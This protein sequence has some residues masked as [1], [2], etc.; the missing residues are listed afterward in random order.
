M[1]S[2]VSKKTLHPSSLNTQTLSTLTLKFKTS[3]QSKTSLEE[4]VNAPTFLPLD[5]FTSLNQVLLQIHL[6]LPLSQ[7]LPLDR[8]TISMPPNQ[9]TKT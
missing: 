4:K 5:L 2:S 3:I 1:D 6:D 7:P 8:P 9:L